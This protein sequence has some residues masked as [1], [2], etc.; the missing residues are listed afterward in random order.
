MAK[1]KTIG[2]FFGSRSPEHDISIITGQLIISG[3]KALGYPVVPV[4]LSKA[5]D[6]YLG[7]RYGDIEYFKAEKP[8][9]R[10]GDQYTL[11][12]RASAEKLVFKKTGMFGFGVHTIDIAFPALH[13]QMGEDGTIQGLFDLLNVPYVG[14]GVTASAVTMDKVLTKQ[15]YEEQGISTTPYVWFTKEEWS[16]DRRAVLRQVGEKLKYPLFVKPAR[17]GSSIGI[18]KVRDK[19]NLER[20]VE[21][22]L[23]YDDKAIVENAVEPLM[24]VTVAV[25]GN[26]DDPR[27]SLL[28]ES[29]F[30]DS[31]FSYEEKYLKKGGAQLGKAQD[32]IVIPARLAESTTETIQGMAAEIYK[33]FECSGTARVDFLVNTD[34]GEIFA[35]EINTLPGTLYHHLWKASG[36]SLNDLLEHL[37][38]FAEERHE[39]RKKLTTTFASNVLAAA[40]GSK[41]KLGD[42]Q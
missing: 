25:L 17:L 24:D 23:H 10:R 18:E 30:Q 4:Y 28:Q 3:L 8:K 41:G 33:L 35:N 9:L 21:V 11:D 26:S 5:G 29:V 19:E 39:R 31:L 37:L 22:A 32:S 20:A 38:D 14:C 36:V 27:P 15:L 40:G 12:L 2:V 1:K 6:W 42:S 13:G 7:D 34:T 16:S